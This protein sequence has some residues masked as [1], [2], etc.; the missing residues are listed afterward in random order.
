MRTGPFRIP[1]TADKAP[2]PR[3]KEGCLLRPG[4]PGI[5][6]TP[7]QKAVLRTGERHL[8]QDDDNDERGC[9]GRNSQ[10]EQDQPASERRVR[11]VE[12]MAQVGVRPFGHEGIGIVYAP[13]GMFTDVTSRPYAERKAQGIAQN[14]E[15]NSSDTE[16]RTERVGRRTGIQQEREQQQGKRQDG[17]NV[18]AIPV[19][20][21][22]SL[23]QRSPRPGIPCR[24]RG[25]G[26]RR[27]RP[28]CRGLRQWSTCEARL[29]R[30]G[31]PRAEVPCRQ[32][33]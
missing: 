25:S 28:G 21:L 3:N 8:E 30:P 24:R 33:Q 23:R 32:G 4:T 2:E 27:R 1:P 31:T 15:H 16:S 14:A 6:E 29:Q 7:F 17:E 5:P 26:P 20:E 10:P 12:R 13:A 9:Q 19:Y 11:H 22:A 18:P